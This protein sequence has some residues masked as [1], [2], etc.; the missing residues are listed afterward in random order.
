[1]D[2]YGLN[3]KVCCDE[4]CIV[5]VC[6]EDIS[7][8]V[9]APKEPITWEEL[10]TKARFNFIVPKPIYI[11]IERPMYG[12]IFQF[13]NYDNEYIYEHGKTNGYA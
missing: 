1:M 8:K 12:T 3:D 9:V 4:E 6:G 10:I 13:G 11:I 2:K 7:L 5:Y